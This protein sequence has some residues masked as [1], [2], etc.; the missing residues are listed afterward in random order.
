M[1]PGKAWITPLMESSSECLLFFDLG[2]VMKIYTDQFLREKILGIQEQPFEKLTIKKQNGMC[3]L[4]YR[5]K[6][7]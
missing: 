4:K 3:V 1:Y 7:V 6:T 5:R 2:I